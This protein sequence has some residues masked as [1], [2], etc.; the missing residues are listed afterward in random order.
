M[1]LE[2]LFNLKVK[3]GGFDSKALVLLLHFML[4]SQCG[5]RPI[6]LCITLAD[7]L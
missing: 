7:N 6:K 3:N 1:L 4:S 2:H 5:P